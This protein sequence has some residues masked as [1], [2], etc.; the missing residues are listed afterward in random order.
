MTPSSIEPCAL[1]LA[2]EQLSA[3]RDRLLPPDDLARIQ[4]H[5]VACQAC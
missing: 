1:G 3:V 4:T 5:V 2:G